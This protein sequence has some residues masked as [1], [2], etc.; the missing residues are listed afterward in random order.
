MSASSE[1]RAVRETEMLRPRLRDGL[2][3]RIH[4]QGGRRVCVIE[5]PQRCRFHR[6][7]LEEYRFLRALDG[8]RP[9]AAILAQQAR[10]H[11]STAFT[12]HE[13]VQMLRWC[14]DNDLLA[15]EGARAGGEREAVQR[16]FASA[17]RWLNPLVLK[18]PLARPDGFFARTEPALRWALGGFG[19]LAWLIVLAIGAASVGTDWARFSHGFEGIL[20]RDNWLWLFVVWAVLKSIHEF[21]HGIFCRHFGAAVREIG[22]IFILFVPM[23]YV[24]ATASLGL[25]SKWRRMIVSAAGL[26]A[27]FFVAALAALAWAHTAP[28]QLGTA[29]HNAVV[30]GTMVTLFFN[31]NPLMRF[32]G[33]YLLSDALEIPNLATRGRTWFTRALLW[34]FTG[35]A[36][37]RPAWPRQRDEWVVA[38]YGVASSVWQAVVLAG[39]LVSASA[40]LRGGG[41][42]LAAGAGVMWVAMPLWQFGESLA[43]HAGRDPRRWLACA[44][45]AALAVALVAALLL[46]PFRRAVSS[47]G[48]VEFADTQILRAECPGFVERIAV[49]DGEEVAAGQLLVELRNDE[50]QGDL[51][52][53]RLELAQQELRARVAY[54]REDV[55]TFQAQNAKA[56]SLRSEVAQRE[57]FIATLRVVAPFA[58]FVTNRH[59]AQFGGVF[60]RPGEEVLRIGRTAGHDVKVAVSQE[61]EPHV[62]SAADRPVRVRIE[63]RGASL[64]AT[65]AHLESRATRELRHPELT[66][67]ADGP[68]ALRRTEERTPEDDAHAPPYELAE[69]QFEATVHLSAAPDLR[70]GELARVKFLSDRRVT[71]WDLAQSAATRWLARYTARRGTGS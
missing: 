24:D 63:G 33:Y 55:A 66:A 35:D 5:D 34:L 23:G 1:N 52:H 2:H 19:F 59:L 12:E 14:K 46:M 50:V 49:H 4:E 9:V 56:E 29:L 47:P 60:I 42:L 7:G 38:L 65:L 8:A 21:S 69:P 25:P 13:A 67:L 16:S 31:A 57:K 27:E 70:P 36:S 68:L 18:L 61:N 30:T 3:F 45:R 48:V 40:L 37:A 58:G 51:T 20:A 17:A 54:T 15:V 44:G 22:V 28:G 41:L 71:F 53:T 26:Y 64:P 39:L 10:A 43:R 32:D 11:G 62:R 6:V